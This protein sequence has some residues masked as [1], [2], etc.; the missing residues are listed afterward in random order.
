MSGSR[1]V[2]RRH[3]DRDP[4]GGKDHTTMKYL[5]L[6]YAAP[7]AG[8]APGTPEQAAEMQ[9][10]WGDTDALQSAGAL[11]GGEALQGTETATT[12]SRRTGEVVSTDGP[13]AETKEVLG[14][15]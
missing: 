5:L 9:E 10:W 6:L 15:F 1:R 7:D 3:A 8:P 12:L 11:L 4:P 14:G 13:F 2:V